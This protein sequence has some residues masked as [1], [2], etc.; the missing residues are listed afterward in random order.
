[1]PAAPIQVHLKNSGTIINAK[2]FDKRGAE[3]TLVLVG[4][5]DEVIVIIKAEIMALVMEPEAAK[6]YFGS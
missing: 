5:D 3:T 2:S 4:M 1:M 6:Y